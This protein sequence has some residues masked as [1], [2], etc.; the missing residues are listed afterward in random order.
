VPGLNQSWVVA[1]G[2]LVGIASIVMTYFGVIYFL[3]GLHSYAEGS[4]P[5]VPTW[6][7]VGGALMLALIAA[8]YVAERR[9]SWE[10]APGA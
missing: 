7:Y 8:S 5:Q 2:T 1:S 10:G 4:A 3:T 9:R 6:V